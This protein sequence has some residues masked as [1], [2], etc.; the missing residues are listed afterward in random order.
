MFD[1]SHVTVSAITETPESEFIARR[2][3]VDKIL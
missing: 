1:L 3:K 2:K